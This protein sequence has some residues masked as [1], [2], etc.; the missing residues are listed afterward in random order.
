MAKQLEVLCI[1]YTHTQTNKHTHTRTH[2]H[3][4][5]H[6]YAQQSHTLTHARAYTG[7]TSQYQVHSM[8][9]F[10]NKQALERLSIPIAELL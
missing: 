6:A 10:T 3:T 8:I 7:G 1:P 5:T 4:H 2:A 9:F